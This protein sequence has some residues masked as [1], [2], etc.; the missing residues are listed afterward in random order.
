MMLPI[1]DLVSIMLNAL[2]FGVYWG[3]WLA[4]SRSMRAFDQQVFLAIVHRMDRNMGTVM[5]VLMPI[6]LLSI[7]PVLVIGHTE[8]PQTFY[9]TLAGL[10]FFVLAAIVTIA[11]EVPIVSRIRTWSIDSMPADWTHQRDRW[12]SFHRIRVG[13]GFVGLTLLV[14][15]ALFGN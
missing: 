15:G 8:R 12:V 14:V 4:L 13:S 10:L 1:L 6:S 11:I 9:L 2:V 3:P 5:T 7:V